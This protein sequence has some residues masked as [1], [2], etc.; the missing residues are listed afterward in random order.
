MSKKVS[1]TKKA[2]KPEKKK[3]VQDREYLRGIANVRWQKVWEK[4]VAIAAAG[5][6]KIIT[7]HLK[8]AEKRKNH[9]IDATVL[10]TDIARFLTPRKGRNQKSKINK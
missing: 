4:K 3:V 5:I 6:I 8:L 10:A 9:S 7:A 2:T 1:K